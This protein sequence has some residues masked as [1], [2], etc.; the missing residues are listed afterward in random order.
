MAKTN[1]QL[2]KSHP[3]SG[4]PPIEDRGSAAT[5]AL[6]KL[7]PAQRTHLRE[8]A[9][10]LTEAGRLWIDEGDTLRAA[11]PLDVLERLATHEPIVT[12]SVGRTTTTTH[13]QSGDSNRSELGFWSGL[14]TDSSSFAASD[15]TVRAEFSK[16]YRVINDL[17]DLE[18]LSTARGLP[19][20]DR[21]S[22]T[23]N[24]YTLAE[25]H[26][27]QSADEHRREKGVFH[28]VSASWGN[29]EHFWTEG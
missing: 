8:L 27:A 2:I 25:R 15:R 18:W 20:V 10:K 4:K 28:R 5:D 1:L 7:D 19:G 16:S 21:I 29:S 26:T 9:E 11:E 17:E 12:L 24:T 3:E 22:K 23:G 6:S 14:A 13:Q